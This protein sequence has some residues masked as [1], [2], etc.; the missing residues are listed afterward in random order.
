MMI[1]IWIVLAISAGIGSNVFNFFSRFILKDGGDSNSWAWTF[2]LLRLIIFIPLV[3]FDYKFIFTFKSLIILLSIG[4][5]EFVS[6]YLFM[7]MHQYS[8]LSISTIISRTRLVWV[9]LIAFLFFGER[10]TNIDY[11]GIGILFLGLSIAVAPHKLFYDKGVIYANLAAFMI[12]ILTVLIKQATPFA[13]PPIIMIF[14][15]LPSVILFPIFMKNLKKRLVINNFTMLIPKVGAVI[16]N[17]IAMYL[18]IIALK[19]G[20]VSKV[21]AIYQSM[22]VVGVLSGIIIL[23]EKQDIARKIIGTIV[24][25]AGIILLT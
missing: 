25:L 22:L 13:S 9:P 17:V 11:L 8:H 10:L 6:I 18:L 21:N 5:T 7:K 19:L 20:D 2:E 14:F 16:I 15:S 23:K 1:P 4:L 12:A 24:T 3:F